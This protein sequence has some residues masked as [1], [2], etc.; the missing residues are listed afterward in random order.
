MNK[1]EKNTLP[2]TEPT[3]D[4]G[5][6][7][8]RLQADPR[9]NPPTPSVWKRVALVVVV[10]VLFWLAFSMRAPLQRE[11]R[12]VHAQRYSNEFKYR[13]AASPIV[14]EKLKDGRQRIRGAQPTFR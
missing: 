1:S 2:Q 8:R 7:T 13:P 5:E 3:S 4:V 14:T 11:Q 6:L 10:F 9:F 12:V